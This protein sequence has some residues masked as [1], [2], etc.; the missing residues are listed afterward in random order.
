MGAAFRKR[1]PQHLQ[2]QVVIVVEPDGDKFHAFCPALKGL[3]ADGSTAEEAASEAAQAVP[4][5][6]DSLVKH[7][8]PLPLGVTVRVLRHQEEIPEIPEG[9]FL[10]YVNLQWPS[11]QIVPRPT[12]EWSRPKGR[13][14]N[15]LPHR[16]KCLH[17]RSTSCRLGANSVV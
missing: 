7:G 10:R 3:H 6:V 14:K 13:Q 4:A 2:F 12:V 9:A 5:Y 15:P 1:T 8:E 17:T 16:R 11:L